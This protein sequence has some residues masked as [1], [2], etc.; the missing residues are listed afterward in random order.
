MIFEKVRWQVPEIQHVTCLYI[1]RDMLAQGNPY[2]V[3]FQS[4]YSFPENTYTC[5]T[6]F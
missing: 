6:K 5:H 3:R 1:P 4:G 2:F